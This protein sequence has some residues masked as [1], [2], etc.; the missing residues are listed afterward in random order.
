[1]PQFFPDK[2]F[3]IGRVTIPPKNDAVNYQQFL[4]NRGGDGVKYFEPAM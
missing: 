4:L 1:M 3:W 2:E